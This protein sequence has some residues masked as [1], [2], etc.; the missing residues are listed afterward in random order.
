VPVQINGGNKLFVLAVLPCG[1]PAAQ[2]PQ[3]LWQQCMLHE[4]LP[5]INVHR[6]A[7]SAFAEAL[8]PLRTPDERYDLT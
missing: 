4:T 5:C 3:V 6:M 2:N 7:F 8:L 1:G